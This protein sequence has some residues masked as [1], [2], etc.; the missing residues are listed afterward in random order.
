MASHESVDISAWGHGSPLPT[1][2]QNPIA[3]KNLG[4]LFAS[5]A[6]FTKAIHCF[7]QS[8]A[9]SP[10]QIDVQCNLAAVLNNHADGL[11]QNGQ[12]T[13]GMAHLHQSL[14]VNPMQAEVHYNLGNVFFGI[15]NL[16]E[17][18]AC[19]GQAIKI[20]PNHHMALWELALLRLVQGD[21]AGGWPGFEE[22]IHLP[23]IG[24][25]MFR[26]PRW[27]GSPLAGKTL[28]VYADA[29]LGDTL[30][31][32]RYLPMVKVLADSLIFECQPS[33]C[34]LLARIPGH[35]RIVS[36]AESLPPF[37]VQIPLLSLP[38]LFGTTINSIPASQALCAKPKR[39]A[40]WQ[41]EMNREL[42]RKNADNE[43]RIGIVWQ[44]STNQVRDPRSAPL[45]CF[46]PLTNLP[47]VQ[48]VSLQVGSGA[49]QVASATFPILDLGSR[50]DPDSFE[51]AA[52]AM[53][54]LDLV[55]TVDTASA[56]LA[57][58]LGLP[59]WVALPFVA[60]WQYQ[61]DRADS[62][63][64]PSM[65]LFRQSKLGDWEELFGRIAD[66]L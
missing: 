16:S 66:S 25:R 39:V 55:I 62:P 32:S 58:S 38:G 33:L 14:H 4:V 43:I 40:Y 44:G 41:E 11:L 52:A 19:Y 63:W 37:D 18:A 15:G 65:R 42:P 12:T 23:I 28:L 48:L 57:G 60:S 45:S 2:A 27:D 9:F 5:K 20:N 54:S 24:Q 6:Q 3:L 30:Q 10:N 26:Q 17:A 46:E 8:L 1:N 53:T 56:H 34:S 7:R 47:G 35:A 29:G 51:D 31:F 13:D 61:L 59:V 49:E 21:F 64:Y 50:F 36:A 22:R